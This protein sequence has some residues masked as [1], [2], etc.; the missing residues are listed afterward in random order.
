MKPLE[1]LPALPIGGGFALLQGVRVLDLT[2]SIAGPYAT[3]LLGDFGAEVVKVERPGGGDDARHWG[4]PFLNGES[5]WFLSV[6]RNKQSIAL[7]YG[8]PEGHALLLELVTKADVVVLNQLPRQ[9]A[10]LRTD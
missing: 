10:R 4:P 5:L 9:Q 7:D 8:R 6:N 3:M 2:T 1:Q